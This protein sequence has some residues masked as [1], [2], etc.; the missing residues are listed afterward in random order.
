MVTLEDAKAHLRIDED[1]SDDMV[2][3]NVL[4]AMNAG[5]ARMLGAV[6]SDVETYLPEDP[7]IDQLTLIYTQENYDGSSLSEK[8][9]RALKHLREDLE[10]QLRLDLRDAKEA[11]GVI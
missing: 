11:A 3:A 5:R 10:P 2:N 7:R 9:I 8:E 1:D 4:R 6:G